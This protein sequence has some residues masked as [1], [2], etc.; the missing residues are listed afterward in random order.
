[1]KCDRAQQQTAVIIPQKNRELP[2]T[3]QQWYI[4]F[5]S[6]FQIKANSNHRRFLLSSF[7]AVYS[8]LLFAQI[9]MMIVPF[10]G[11]CSMLNAH[12]QLH[13]MDDYKDAS[14]ETRAQQTENKCK[15]GKNEQSKA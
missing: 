3:A 15:R 10:L 7:L 5:D 12:M 11:Y 8:P 6:V 4:P 1:M 2:T 13:T 9:E 14:F